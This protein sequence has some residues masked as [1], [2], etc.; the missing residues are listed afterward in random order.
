MKSWNGNQSHWNLSLLGSPN[1]W[2][3][4]SGCNLPAVLADKNVVPQHNDEIVW[5]HGTKGSFTIK[6]IYHTLHERSSQ[7]HFHMPSRRS[8]CLEEEESVHH[9]GSLWVQHLRSKMCWRLGEG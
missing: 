4:E 1:D 7:G 2:E 3:E 8:M 9:L 5:P 6:S